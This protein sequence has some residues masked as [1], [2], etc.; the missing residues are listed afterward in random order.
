MKLSTKILS[1]KSVRYQQMNDLYAAEKFVPNMKKITILTFVAYYLPGYKSGGPVRTIAN[2]VEHF[3]DE[4]DFWIVTKDRDAL[5]S[6]PY[7][8][9]AINDWNTVGKAQVY[10]ASPDS[11]SFSKISKLIRETT[12]DVLYLNSFFNPHFTILPLL[13]RRVG[14]LPDKPVV[15]APRGEFSAGALS[16]KSWKKS[17]FLMLSRLFGLYGDLVWQASSEHEAADIQQIMGKKTAVRIIIAPVLPTLPGKQIFEPEEQFC[18]ETGDPL[19]VIFLS[20]I[21]PKKNLDFALKVL[22]KTTVFVV[23]NIYGPV[24][25]ESYWKFCESFL[26]KM[27]S[28]VSINYKG[29]VTPDEVPELMARH[30][31]F[32]FPTLGENYG[33]VIPESLSAGTP[34]LI[35]NTT[36]WRDLECAGVGWNL[37]LNQEES[38]VQCIEH[39]FHL[40]GEKYRQWRRKV[41]RYALERLSDPQ[42]IENNR[43]IFM[44]AIKFNEKIKK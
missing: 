2:M 34:V 8:N 16:L 24:R 1:Q 38:F 19:R 32:F 12:Y 4:F 23:F 26:Q 33:H 7:P 27:P 43:H 42:I 6:E 44:E 25:D 5:D 29:M 37:P 15:Q 36:P 18:R 30:D 10:Y 17:P 3:G 13:A 20:R 35:A 14:L 31:L 21:T 40:D 28:N 11:L 39:C 41:K 9:I 22:A